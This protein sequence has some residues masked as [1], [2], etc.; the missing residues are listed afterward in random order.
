[1]TWEEFLDWA[2]EDDKAEWVD[3]EVVL[4]MPET[5]LHNDLAVFLTTLFQVYVSRF[6]LGKV[7]TSF[8]MRLVTRPS[9]RTPDVLFVAK[10][11]LDRMR[12]TYVDG[13]ADL[14]VELVSPSSQQRDVVEKMAEY[15]GAHLPEYWVI[16]ADS[17]DAAF[18]VLGMDGAYHRRLPD[19]AGIYR[20][21]AL[22]GFWLRV[23]WLWQNPHPQ[24]DALRE[25]GLV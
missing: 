1:V 20:S 18:Y 13:P 7:F 23:E 6:G 25:L 12:G 24:I 10:E 16:D 14:A 22:P 4:L 17:R 11:H 15:A 19:G 9:G 8:L 2:G 21:V 3:G 5:E